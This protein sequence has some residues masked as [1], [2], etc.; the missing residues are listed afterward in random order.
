MRI[1]FLHTRFLPRGG[2]EGYIDGLAR[3]LIAAGHEVHGFC[4]FAEPPVPEGL[5]LR[6]LPRPPLPRALDVLLFAET[7]RRAPARAGGFDIIHGFGKTYA[8]DVYTEAGGCL[9]DVLEATL[10]AAPSGLR[11]TL[12]RLGPHR[13]AVEWIERRRYGRPPGPLGT[14]HVLAVSR[15]C[16][17]QVERRYPGRSG[18][19]EVLYPPVDATALAEARAGKGRAAL[20]ERLRVSPQELLCLFVGS[21]YGRKGLAAF[22]GA[23][24]R[25][26]A[27]GVRAR[28][29]VLGRER[30]SVEAAFRAEAVSLGL[31]ALVRFE[32]FSA[33][34]PLYLAAADL[35]VLPTRF[36]AFGMVVLEAMAAGVPPVV[37]ARAGAAEVVRDGETGAVVRDPLD[38]EELAARIRALAPREVR[39]KVGVAAAR[40]AG[41]FS[42]E[43]NVRRVVEVYEAAAAEKRPD[44]LTL[45][46]PATILPG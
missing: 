20:R 44:A 6:R 43:A 1:A 42:W 46:A 40:E 36:D 39:A 14:G 8:Q 2:I 5:V 34:V 15:L 11:R 12:K 45:A 27:A 32:G 37:S 41:R 18:T 31:G 30:P 29:V 10:P 22:L 21:G 23:I 38:A 24:A 7:A 4:H 35:L 19:V 26:A 3:R 25:L 28:G 13:R 9:A 16:R 33:E 17:E